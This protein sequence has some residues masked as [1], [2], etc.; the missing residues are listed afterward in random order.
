MGGLFREQ[1]LEVVTKWLD[2]VFQPHVEA[3]YQHFRN[4]YESQA[5]LQPRILTAPYPSLPS[6]TVSEGVGPDLSS[7]PTGDRHRSPPPRTNKPQQGSG[8]VGGSTRNCPGVND[9]SGNNRRRGRP[10]QVDS[11]RGDPGKRQPV[12]PGHFLNNPWHH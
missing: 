11:K 1:G 4:D 3:A 12:S 7:R 10:S 9:Q 6:Y 2:S 5:I 8:R